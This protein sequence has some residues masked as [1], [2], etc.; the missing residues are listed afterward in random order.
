MG[1]ADGME[2]GTK[3]GLTVGFEGAI[4]GTTVGLL[5]V[6]IN[7]GLLGETVG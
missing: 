5:E 6:G 3:D 4:D 7:V 1:E 2:L